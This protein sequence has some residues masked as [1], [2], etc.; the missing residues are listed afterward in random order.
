MDLAVVVEVLISSHLIVSDWC[1]DDGSYF[2]QGFIPFLRVLRTKDRHGSAVGMNEPANG[3]EKSGLTSS[4]LA[5]QS[6]NIAFL[7]RK[8]H[9]IEGILLT[10]LFGNLLYF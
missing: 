2:A 4:V 5:N 6:I 3:L 8:T 9:M 7:N 1:F 10:I